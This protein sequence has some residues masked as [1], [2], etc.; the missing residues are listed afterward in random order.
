MWPYYRYPAPGA[1]F[2]AGTGGPAPVPA[3]VL[4]GDDLVPVLNDDG[5]FIL[6]S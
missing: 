5:S 1:M 2:I 3:N 4:R 6:V